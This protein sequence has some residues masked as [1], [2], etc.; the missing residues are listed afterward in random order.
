MIDLETIPC[1][2]HEE[3]WKLKATKDMVN[4]II[5]AINAIQGQG[6][7]IVKTNPEDAFYNYFE[8]KY[9][10]RVFSLGLSLALNTGPN[11]IRIALSNMDDICSV[12]DK[13]SVDGIFYSDIYNDVNDI[14]KPKAKSHRVVYEIVCNLIR[15]KGI[16]IWS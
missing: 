8:L 13:C 15:R 6:V 16:K 5:N 9:Q 10:E 1:D 11:V 14:L 2:V 7:E 4:D 3:K 12:A